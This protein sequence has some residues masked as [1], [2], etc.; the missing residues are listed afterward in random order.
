MLASAMFYQHGAVVGD[1]QGSLRMGRFDEFIIGVQSLVVI[2]PTYVL[3]VELFAHTR[4]ANENKQMA[5]KASAE[6]K[7]F[8]F[9]H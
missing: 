4:S 1:T 6:R 2:F 8:S 9:P 5:L 3:T 7:S